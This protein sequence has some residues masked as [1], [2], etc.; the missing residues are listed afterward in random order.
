MYLFYLRPLEQIDVRQVS[1]K[2]K[3]SI[4]IIT[5]E[6]NNERIGKAI[7]RKLALSI[8]MFFIHWEY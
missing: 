7:C 6:S 1:M 4:A 8:E 5:V 2:S 3:K